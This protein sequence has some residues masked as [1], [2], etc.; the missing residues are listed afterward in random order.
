METLITKNL[1]SNIKHF[2]VDIFRYLRK[3]LIRH[4]IGPVST[5]TSNIL[6]IFDR[7]MDGKNMVTE[8]QEVRLVFVLQILDCTQPM[9]H[10]HC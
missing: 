5:V 7:L 4:L 1:F 9:L 6:P 10:Q 3:H 8:V 2:S